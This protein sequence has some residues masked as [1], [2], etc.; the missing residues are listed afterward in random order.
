MRQS[1]GIATVVV[2]LLVMSANLV[3]AETSSV[4]GRERLTRAMQG[5]WLPLEGGLEV[6]EREGTSLSA[7]YEIDDGAFRLSIYTSKNGSSSGEAFMEVI[8]D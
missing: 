5:A 4:D 8:V 6:G 2:L 7:K 3:V 1:I